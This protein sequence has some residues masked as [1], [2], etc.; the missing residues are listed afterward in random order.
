[1]QAFEE[2]RRRGGG[3]KHGDAVVEL[4]EGEDAHGEEV[5]DECTE[6]ERVDGICGAVGS[7]AWGEAAL[8]LLEVI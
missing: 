5:P 1:M 8:A 7:V 6:G 3:E 4:G 2:I